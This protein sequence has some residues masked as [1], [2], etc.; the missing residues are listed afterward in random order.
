METQLTRHFQQEV[1]LI[2]TAYSYNSD[3]KQR[4]EA[5][6]QHASDLNSM[7]KKSL[8]ELTSRLDDAKL[9]ELANL[10]STA[11]GGVIGG[12]LVKFFGGG[13]F[14]IIGGAL[15][16]AV[17]GNMFSPAVTTNKFNLKFI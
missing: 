13:V 7:Q 12:L 4:V 17:V 14:S 11:A 9:I 10:L 1:Q 15:A 5:L 3:P 6:I 2:K 16:G 8:L